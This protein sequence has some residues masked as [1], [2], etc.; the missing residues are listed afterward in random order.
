MSGESD[1][2]LVEW[3]TSF[4]KESY[5]SELAEFQETLKE[6][7]VRSLTFKLDTLPSQ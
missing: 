4:T 3:S 1:T 6:S 2:T 5:S 7:F